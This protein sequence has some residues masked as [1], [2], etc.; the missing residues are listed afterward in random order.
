MSR[1][2]QQKG[3]VSIFVVVF[4]SLLVS[5]VT[6]SFVQI[7]LRNQQQ[8]S[9]NDLSQSAYDSALAGVE[10]AKRA[11]VRLKECEGNGD[12][13]CSTL[14]SYLEQDINNQPCDVLGTDKAGVVEFINGEVPVQGDG[15]ATNPLNQA[16]TC[17]KV[18]VKT[19]FYEGDLEQD[20][21]VVIPLDSDQPSENMIT[22]VR[23]SWFMQ[24][25]IPLDLPQTPSYTGATGISLPPVNSTG[26]P[27]NRP[28]LMRSQLIQFPKGN[29][30]INS[31]DAVGNVNSRTEFLYPSPVGLSTSGFNDDRLSSAGISPTLALCAGSFTLNGSYACSIDMSVP[32]LPA[33]EREAYLMLTSMYNKTHYKV[34]LIGGLGSTLNFDNVQPKVDSTGRASDLFRRVSASVSITNSMP[35]AY[36]DAAIYLNRSL[37]KDFSITNVAGDYDPNANGGTQCTP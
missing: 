34:E 16:Y 31:F 4:T 30:D 23:I 32:A 12:A 36:P 27:K 37:C 26:W 11:L 7:M 19:D 15:D 14:R 1:S 10:D 13:D 2:N 9:N 20:E 18:Q 35:T 8:A 29:L 21:S 6:L 5:V 3:A 22:G 33:G 28:S 17:V 24:S 25:D